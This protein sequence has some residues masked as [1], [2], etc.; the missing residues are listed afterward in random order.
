M[1]EDLKLKK[2]KVFIFE[3][4]NLDILKIFKGANGGYKLNKDPKDITLRDAVETIEEEI[5]IKDRSCVVGQTSC[6]VI[7]KALEEVENNFLNN[8]DKVNFK[9]LTC[10]HVDLK[11]DDEIK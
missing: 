2:K 1:K 10:P 11:I 8:L 7:F 4:L 5:I 3:Y 6:S 9:E